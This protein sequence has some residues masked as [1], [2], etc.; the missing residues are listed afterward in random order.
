MTVSDRK[1]TVK[2]P[3]EIYIVSFIILWIFM[4]WLGT[5]WNCPTSCY[6]LMNNQSKLRYKNV[7]TY[8][9]CGASDLC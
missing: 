4:T 5:N 2:I 1:I 6:D 9:G 3:L 8:R 7:S